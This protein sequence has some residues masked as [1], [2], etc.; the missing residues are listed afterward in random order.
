MNIAILHY[1]FNRGGVTQVVLNQLR[2]IDAVL[3]GKKR[4]RVALV[5]GGRREGIADDQLL[6]FRSI[7]LSMHVI[8]ALDYD[9]AAQVQ[10]EA[11]AAE[12]C[13]V[14]ARA[15]FTAGET[16]LHVHNHSLGKNV[17][18]PGAIRRLAQGGFRCLLQIHDFAEDLRPA[19]YRR[20]SESLVPGGELA[21]LLYPQASHIHYAVLNGRD[22]R[23][24]Q[25]AQVDKD[26]LHLL[27][28]S[29][30]EFGELPSKQAAR[31]KLRERFGVERETRF[32]VYPVRGIR[33]K[34]VGEMLL[35]SA[36]GANFGNAVFAITLEPLNPVEQKTY[37]HWSNLADELRLP[38]VF[39]IGGPGGLEFKEN[40]AAADLLLTTSIAEGFGMVFLEAWLAGRNLVGRG[41]PEI[42]ADFV[43][44][45]I[46]LDQLYDQLL[47]PIQWVGRDELYES[48]AA[49]YRGLLRDYAI[50]VP[51]PDTM[52]RRISTL[53]QQDNIDFAAL[54]S[55]QQTQVIRRVCNDVDARQHVLKLNPRVA[56]AFDVDSAEPL[57]ARNAE[58]VRQTYSLEA[59]GRRLLRLYEHVA[60]SPVGAELQDLPAAD[61]ILGAYL[62]VSR[63]YPIRFEN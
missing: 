19:N 42:T 56:A 4:L 51:S 7:E 9:D 36:L 20:L 11:L 5:H 55:T 6:G 41:L 22:Q 50:D 1:H 16:L 54:D 39:N 40:L 48:F 3:G 61:Q 26:R 10:D 44:A 28:N 27:P 43:N 21:P 52:Q 35:W 45:G 33:R 63:L 38:C 53:L 29:V 37:C 30:A 47:V 31:A 18:L 60:A 46:S 32:V 8:S 25:R 14:L 62:D 58:A 59:S 49:A 12:I 57:I 24:L 13:D 23:V 34:N 15:D 2:A 17:S